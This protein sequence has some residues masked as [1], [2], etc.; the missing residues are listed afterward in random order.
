VF[1]VALDWLNGAPR[2]TWYPDLGAAREYTVRGKAKL[3]DAAWQTPT[4]A[5]SRFFRVDAALR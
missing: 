5:A 1:R 3:S 4:N 2:L